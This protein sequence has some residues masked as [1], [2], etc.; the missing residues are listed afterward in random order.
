[1]SPPAGARLV[2]RQLG[3]MLRSKV[4]GEDAPARAQRIWG[5]QGERWF[6]PQDPVWRVHADASMFPAGITS[7]LLQMLHPMAMAGVAGHS[8]YKSDPWGR[9]QRTSH[10]LATTTFGTVEH[11]EEAIAT[12]RSI[13]ERVRG[14]DHLGRPYR[15][16]DPHLLM[17]V[18]AAEIDSFLRGYQTFGDT[19]LTDEEA[20]VYVRQAGI[21]A[22]LLGVP[23]P[24]QSVAELA[25]VLDSYRPEL[26][27]TPAAAEAA[28]FLLLDPP[29]P[30]Y[31]RPGYGTLA[32][33]GVSLLPGWAREMLG[34]PVPDVVA[35]LVA[36]PL[37]HLGTAA[38]RWGMAGLAERRPSDTPDDEPDDDGSPRH[39]DERGQ[40]VGDLAAS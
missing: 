9:L 7:L 40:R 11:A 3:R 23:S 18:H 14:K 2:Q 16:S 12:V 24:P 33:G 13:H 15:A 25:E 17:W 10:Y 37:G 4:A 5:A 1:M 21:P 29:L 34:L 36:R 38:V 31:A 35:A 32:S 26:E 39:P 6:T 22:A 30:F 20:D 19:P 27:A 8:G 28:R